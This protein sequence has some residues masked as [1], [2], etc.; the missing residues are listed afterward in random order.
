MRRYERICVCFERHTVDYHAITDDNDVVRHNRIPQYRHID[1]VIDD[2][3]MRLHRSLESWGR[4]IYAFGMDGS[5]K[6]RAT[7]D[8]EY[9]Y[10]G[11][12][13]GLEFCHG[14][15]F[16]S[17]VILLFHLGIFGSGNQYTTLLFAQSYKYGFA[18]P[19]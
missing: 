1:I 5:L 7:A 10:T 16:Q 18:H 6:L 15:T 14:D 11:H 13:V 19:V 3:V 4:E 17:V 9:E 12:Y 8:H 2:R